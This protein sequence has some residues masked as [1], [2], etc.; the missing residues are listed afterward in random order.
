MLSP[1][2]AAT[3]TAALAVPA[4]AAGHGHPGGSVRCPAQLGPCEVGVHRHTHTP[5]HTRHGGRGHQA[6]GGKHGGCVVKATG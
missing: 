4:A 1:A 5:G 3:L 2:A 6:N